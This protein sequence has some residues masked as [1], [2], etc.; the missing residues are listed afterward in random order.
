MRKI[1]ISTISL[2]VSF[3]LSGNAIANCGTMTMADMNWPSATLM[4]NVDKIILEEGYGCE[5]ELVTGATTTTFA[6]MNEK[7]QPDVAPELWI[8]AVREPLFAAMDEGRLHSAKDMPIGGLGEGWW[9]PK[10]TIEKNPELKTVLDILERPDLLP[11]EE[12]KFENVKLA[13]RSYK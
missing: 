1:L 4:A 10:Y 2:F 12:L 3:L 8:N 9:I 6:S 7:S 5:I 13:T 11:Q